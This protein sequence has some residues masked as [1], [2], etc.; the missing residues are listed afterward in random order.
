MKSDNAYAL[1]VGIANYQKINPLPAIVLKDA[2]DIYNLLVSSEHC[3]YKPN[4]VELLLDN[5][6]TQTNLRQSLQTLAKNTN[7]ESSVLIY[8]SSHGGQLKNEPDAGEYLLP[9]DADG[10]DGS[11]LAQSAI[12]STELTKSLRAISARKLVVIFDCC[13]SGGIGQPKIANAPILKEGLSENFYNILEQGQGRVIIA[14]SR[15]NES[16]YI[17]P[18]ATNS[19][20]TQHLLDGLSGGVI[21]QDGVIR[22]LDLFSYIQQRVTKDHSEQHPILKAEIE[23]NFPIALNLGGKSATPLSVSPYLYEKRF[24]IYK[25]VWKFVDKINTAIYQRDFY[26]LIS[27]ALRQ[28]KQE[29]EQAVF[30]FRKDIIEYIEEIENHAKA[31]KINFY[32][33]DQDKYDQSQR[34]R[35]N[36]QYEKDIDWFIDQYHEL[37]NKFIKYLKLN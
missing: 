37:D 7:D 5:Q 34:N 27:E 36:E 31:L 12:S 4:N 9:V 29:T 1:I 14:S 6:A 25:S 10:S 18:G 19:L 15:S 28:F 23:D 21:T 3:G 17:L 35:F 16:S 2:Q 13:H 26:K 11:A 24:P 32:K 8:I 20:F 22:I 33:K 30:F